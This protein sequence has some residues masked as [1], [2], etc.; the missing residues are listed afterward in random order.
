MTLARMLFVWPI[1]VKSCM[2]LFAL[3]PLSAAQIMLLMNR[4]LGS[5]FLTSSRRLRPLREW[6]LRRQTPFPKQNPIARQ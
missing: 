2:V 4:F 6:L 5:H 1:L 3:P